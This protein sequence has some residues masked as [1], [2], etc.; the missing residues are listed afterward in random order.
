VS[1]TPLVVALDFTIHGE[2][3][4]GRL[5]LHSTVHR[6]SP[7]VSRAIKRAL[8]DLTNTF[9]RD[10]WVVEN[11]LSPLLPKFLRMMDFE[12]HGTILC[13]GRE[14]ATFIYRQSN[15]SELHPG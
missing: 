3:H 14:Q 9:Q 12:P 13:N 5:W 4:A 6:W 1:N 7:R 2:Y 10:L 15:G 8:R 11:P